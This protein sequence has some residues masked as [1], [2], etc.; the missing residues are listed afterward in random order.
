MGA[1]GE[2]ESETGELRVDGNIYDPEFQHELNRLGLSIRMSDHTPEEGGVED[3]F[4][5]SSKGAKRVDVSAGPD[6]CVS[7][8][9]I[10]RSI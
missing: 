7:P 1:Y 10:T 9:T 8:L 5:V 4:I 6:V 3:D 2:V